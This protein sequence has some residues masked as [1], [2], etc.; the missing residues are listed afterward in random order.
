MK[1]HLF[2]LAPRPFWDTL[3]IVVIVLFAV[4]GVVL[5]N[6]AATSCPR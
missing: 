5:V 2:H 1:R 4:A 3:V 6:L